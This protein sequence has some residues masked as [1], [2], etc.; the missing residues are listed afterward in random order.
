MN[1]GTATVDRGVSLL[2]SQSLNAN[3]IALIA[4]IDIEF[5][6]TCLRKI[7]MLMDEKTVVHPNRW[8]GS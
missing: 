1:S 7:E 4:N 6:A 2:R 8:L 5:D 3:D